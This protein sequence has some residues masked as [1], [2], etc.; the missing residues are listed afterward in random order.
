[1]LPPQLHGLLRPAAYPHPVTAVVV[2][3]TQ[4]SWVLVA[5]ERAY[6]IK[7][8]VTLPFVDQHR[9]EDRRLLCHEELRLNRRFAPELYLEVCAITA[10]DGA[11]RI[12]GAG[13]AVDYAVVMRSFDRREELDRLAVDG[14]VSPEELAQFGAWLA[15]AHAELPVRHGDAMQSATAVAAAMD[16]NAAECAD[17]AGIFGTTLRVQA[18]RRSLASAAAQH[19]A[20]LAWRAAEGRIR[21][22]HGDLHLS[23][24]VR[25][26]GRL[27]AFDCLE[28]EPAFRWIDVA[29]DA[30]FLHADLLGYDRPRLAAAFLN[31]FLE[32]SGDYHAARVWPLYTADRALV[33]A[34][35]MALRAGMNGASV[36]AGAAEQRRHLGYLQVAES[37]LRPAPPACIMMT[38][39]PGSGKSWLARQLAVELPALLV[40]SDVERKRLAGVGALAE[41]WSRPGAGLYTAE[42]S[43][44]VYA[45][46][47]QCAADALAGGCSVIV[48]ANHN[49]RAQR[50]A[51]AQLCRELPAPLLVIQCEAPD[52]VLRTRLA[53]RAAAHRDASEAGEQVLDFVAGVREPLSAD[54]GLQVVRAD[55]T[56]AEVLVEALL[57]CR[58]LLAAQAKPRAA[59]Q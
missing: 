6:K 16:R 34:K 14:R 20:A 51:L 3:A 30:A 13:P 29:Q 46:L 10:A 25:S 39:L 11:A 18:L 9:L 4:L 54:E 28:Y 27:L 44:A 8:P 2:I 57:A 33:R 43:T 31:G 42:R 59:W 5:G 58:R 55:T 38:G 26:D 24:V 52:A 17:R 19:A 36:A 53:E 47:R 1:M 37:A 48:D 23:N 32:G 12:G 22:C 50:R 45:R 40:R 35:V 7:R 15:G 21:E 41:S 56:R 49:T